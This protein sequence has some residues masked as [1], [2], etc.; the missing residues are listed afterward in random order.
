MK[1]DHIL[2][3]LLTCALVACGSDNEVRTPI[4]QLYVDLTGNHQKTWKINTA[5]LTNDT[6]DLSLNISDHD[7]LLDDEFIFI[8][9]STG[10][11]SEVEAIWRPRSH[12]NIDATTIDELLSEMYVQPR[13][14]Q[15]QLID[16]DRR[17]LADDSGLMDITVISSESISGTIALQND[18]RLHLTLIPKSSNSYKEQPGAL[19]FFEL[20][21]FSGV[22]MSDAPGF[23][24]SKSTNSLYF[25]H[26][27]PNPREAQFEERILKYSIGDNRWDLFAHASSDFVTKQLHI[28]G[29]KLQ[30]VTGLFVNDYPLD[31][32]ST[33]T[34][35]AHGNSLSRF[36]SAVLNDEIYIVGGDLNLVDSDKIKRW[37]ASAAN[38]ETIAQLPAP[39]NWADA[40]IVDNRLYVFGGQET[41]FDGLENNLIYI[42]DFDTQD[43]E[44]LEL[45]VSVFRTYAARYEHLIYIGGQLTDDDPLT[46]DQD[47]LL[48]SFNTENHEFV[49]IK[50]NLSDEGWN[51]IHQLTILHDRLYVIYGDAVNTINGEHNFAIEVAEL[52]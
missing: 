45:P 28:I 26:R 30:V 38:F 36:G 49:T 20:T 13:K 48:G 1:L 37:N 2:L 9:S 16:I 40:E 33:P 21:R 25:A 24:A 4:E 46:L 34:V 42:Y 8:N 43:V 19:S 12:F 11:N 52:P 7:A 14:S 51:T 3:I 29:N 5:T 15:I 41:L 32:L 17:Q 50:T 47:I 10:Q 27:T 35:V 44:I 23:V 6:E 31:I 22:G 18:T 39:K